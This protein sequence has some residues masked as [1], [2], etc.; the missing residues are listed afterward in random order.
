MSL[1]ENFVSAGTR[2][3]R[4]AQWYRPFGVS[5]LVD[6]L[7][8]VAKVAGIDHV[9]IGFDLCDSFKDYLQ[10]E[11]ELPSKDIIKTHADLVPIGSA[12]TARTVIQRRF[13]D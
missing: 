1:P 5:H 11:D 3:K 10:I 12:V 2:K 9:G 13:I 7:D 6:H 8:H 4:Q